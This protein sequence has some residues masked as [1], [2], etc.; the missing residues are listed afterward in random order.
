MTIRSKLTPEYKYMIWLIMHMISMLVDYYHSYIFNS[1]ERASPYDFL[2]MI[3]AHDMIKITWL[4][5][6]E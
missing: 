2:T 5:K 3:W 6:I 4:L 1:W